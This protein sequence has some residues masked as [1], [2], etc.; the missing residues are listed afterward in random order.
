M[1]LFKENG[2][3]TAQK[4]TWDSVTDKFEKRLIEVFEASK[5]NKI[6]I[7]SSSPNSF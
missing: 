1:Q 7:K 5:H 6:L 2:L 3:K 4:F